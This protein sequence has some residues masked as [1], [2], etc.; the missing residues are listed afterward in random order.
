MVKVFG[1]RTKEI[2][3]LYLD[4]NFYVIAAG[5]AICIPLAKKC[6]DLMYPL[7]VSNVNCG[8][9]LHYSW[10]M[11]AIVYVGVLVLYFVINRL[12]TRKLSGCVSVRI[13]LTTLVSR[14]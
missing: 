11:Y 4:G 3:K 7:M 8:M 14:N 6:M 13:Y 5:A 1:Y 12:L 2:K 9:N 10:Q